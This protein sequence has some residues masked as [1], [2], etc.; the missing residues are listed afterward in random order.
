[1]KLGFVPPGKEKVIL[2][3][4][5]VDTLASI[6]GQW[7]KGGG[8]AKVDVNAVFSQLQG[9]VEKY[10]NVF[11]LPPYFAYIARA[12]GVLEGIGLSTDPDYAI[13]GECLPYISQRLLA[14]SERTSDALGSFI[15]GAES[16]SATRVIDVD[17]VQLL[18]SGFNKYTTTTSQQYTLNVTPT[19]PT[20][21]PAVGSS[22]EYGTGMY[23]D[24][25]SQPVLPTYSPQLGMSP[26]ITAIQQPSPPVDT[27]R[28]VDERADLLLGILLQTRGGRVTPIQQLILEEIAKIL[29]S[30][31]RASFQSLRQFSGTLPTGRS[32]LGTLVDPLGLFSGSQLIEVNDFD[33]RVLGATNELAKLLGTLAPQE[34]WLRDVNAQDTRLAVRLVANKIWGRRRDI[35]I[36]GVQLARIMLLQTA[37]RVEASSFSGSANRK[38]GGGDNVT[39]AGLSTLVDDGQRLQRAREYLNQM[40]VE[41]I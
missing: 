24:L 6:Y 5:V 38:V 18:V 23:S 14:D 41:E 36:L 4:G 16:G 26:P 31:V 35:G 12:F 29:G 2:E 13:L 17:R 7:A 37:S 1:M 11:I 40:K 22:R 3:Q 25:Q 28:I 32:I 15:Y 39:G 19:T 33:E 10:G 8:A 27:L 21:A 34:E 9:L 20:I 30:A